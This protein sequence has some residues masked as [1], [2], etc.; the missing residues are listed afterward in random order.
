MEIARG[1]LAGDTDS[2]ES[3]Y[4]ASFHH[5]DNHH[6]DVDD[7]AGL[8]NNWAREKVRKG[9]TMDVGGMGNPPVLRMESFGY[10]LGRDLPEGI[11]N[12]DLAHRH[13]EVLFRRMGLAIGRSLSHRGR[14]LKNPRL[15]AAQSAHDGLASKVC[16]VPGM[17]VSE[18]LTLDVGSVPLKKLEDAKLSPMDQYLIL[19]RNGSRPL[20]Q[21][22]YLS[23]AMYATP[24]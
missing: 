18:M 6:H 15:K 14:I 2:C 11:E 7:V 10:C 3:G 8:R 4:M 19:I 13:W 9:L 22:Y 20:Y 21:R 12:P 24:Q 23:S 5:P 17:D 1:N 16:D